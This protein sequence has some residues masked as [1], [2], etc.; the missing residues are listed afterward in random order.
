MEIWRKKIIT[1]ILTCNYGK[2]R[3]R[4]ENLRHQRVQHTIPVQY[5]LTIRKSIGIFFG[6]CYR[7]PNSL[8]G[9]QSTSHLF[10]TSLS[11]LATTSEFVVERLFLY[12]FFLEKYL[13][14]YCLQSSLAQRQL[15]H[16]KIVN[17][18]L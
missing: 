9:I 6:Q 3:S 1:L 18:H 12:F 16:F 17:Q 7:L 8:K 15:V 5:S 14:Q 10:L 11:M 13:P 2:T 4:F